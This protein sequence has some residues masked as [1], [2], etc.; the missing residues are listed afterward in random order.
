MSDLGP[1]FPSTSVLVFLLAG[2]GSGDGGA[3][4]GGD[5]GN[6]DDTGIGDTGDTD[7][8]R[9]L[10]SGKGWL[11][12]GE[13]DNSLFTLAISSTTAPREGEAYHGWLDGGDDGP[14][15]LGEIAVE[16]N[17]VT[18]QAELGFNGLL[19]GYDTFEAWAGTSQSANTDGEALWKG[20]ID[21]DL[22]AAYEALI[23]KS[24]DTPDGEGSIRT[25]ETTAEALA[26][27][28]RSAIED[29][30]ELSVIH[31]KAESIVNALQ[32]TAEDVDGNGNVETIS[33][34]MP[35]LGD[36][37]LIQLILGD[38][39]IAS[40]SVE[41]GHP[42]KDLAKYAWYCTKRIESY[43]DDASDAADIATACAAESYCD[44]AMGDAAEAFDRALNGYD[45]D[46]D[47]TIDMIDEGTIE[48]A[49]WLASQ[50]AYMDVG[51]P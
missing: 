50:M 21:P 3:G 1:S 48:C 14:V 4:K 17:A 34:V 40:A 15:Y 5:G 16:G 10:G 12:D 18:F 42:I 22:K 23:V 25:V 45:A 6:S 39:D 29:T 11:E 9:A 28:T 2:C 20:Q 31:G 49:A 43:A 44:S 24:A 41:Q 35:I 13:T 8:W 19:S 27:V 32:G 36:D 51:V 37:G 46:E 30:S 26:E 47:G 38:L 7:N 33:G